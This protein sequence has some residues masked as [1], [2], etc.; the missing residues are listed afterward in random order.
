MKKGLILVLS[1]PSG[2]GK[3]TIS[4]EIRKHDTNIELSVSATTRLPRVN[5]V[6]GVHYYFIDQDKFDELVEADAFAEYVRKYNSSYGTLK[7]ELERIMNKGHNVLLDIE[8]NGAMNIKRIYPEAVMIFLIP[9]SFD[10]LKERLWN[11]GSETYESF[12]RRNADFI[13]ELNTAD[14]YDYI[15]VNDDLTEAVKAVEQIVEAENNGTRCEPYVA[16]NQL[17]KI[18]KLKKGENIC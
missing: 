3:G 10:S 16:S 2:V 9:K 5:E 4:G 12:E 17:D 13:K 8:P 7:S 6:D 11:R 15:V 1:G 18:E 14:H